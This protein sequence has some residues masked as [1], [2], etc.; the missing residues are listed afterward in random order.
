MCDLFILLSCV[1]ALTAAAPT[2]QT[3]RQI[4]FANLSYPWV[5][6]REL[7]SSTEWLKKSNRDEVQLI[8]GRWTE[9]ENE[10]GG[11]SDLPRLPFSGLVLESVEFGDVTGDQREQAIAALRYDS[12][13]TETLYFVYIYSL[14]D[15]KPDL[16]GYFHTGDRANNG[17][18]RVYADGGNLVVE[19]FD[20]AKQTGDCCS[21]GFMRTRYRWHDGAFV[22]TGQ[23]EPGTPQSSS[24][25]RV[26]T[27]GIH[28]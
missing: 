18:Y 27:F 4:D 19:L 11:T 2:K 3:I 28:Q 26:S 13:G 17:L 14:K 7:Q 25:L 5:E 6:P 10:R 21:S 23:P 16:L 22:A 9:A 15:G 8:K 1:Y 20:P 12:G 24:R